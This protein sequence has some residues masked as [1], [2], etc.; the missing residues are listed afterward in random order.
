MI[1]CD[2]AFCIQLKRQFSDFLFPR[3]PGKWPFTLSDTQVDSRR[4][5]LED[6]M[7]KGIDCVWILNG[8]SFLYSV[9]HKGDI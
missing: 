7:E 4:R 8:T 5:G 6:Y 1:D 3:L 2:F 9:W